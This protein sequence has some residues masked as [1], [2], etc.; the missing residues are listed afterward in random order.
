[1]LRF[2]AT[3][4]LLARATTAADA[5][6][7]TTRGRRYEQA[8]AASPESAFHRDLAAVERRAGRAEAAVDRLRR[9]SS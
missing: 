8:I 9:P 7:L 6:R 5:G 4:D 1:M 2:R 3:Q